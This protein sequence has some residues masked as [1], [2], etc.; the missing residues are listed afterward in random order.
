MTGRDALVAAASALA[1]LLVESLL[2]LA[3]P[4]PVDGVALAQSVGAHLVLFGAVFA[5]LAAVRAT[6][7]LT[8]NP[9]RSESVGA[10]VLLCGMV[11]AAATLVICTTLSIAGGRAA[12]VF[13]FGAVIAARFAARGL[14]HRAGP[15]TR[16]RGAGGQRT[17][18]RWAQSRRLWPRVAW[19]ALIVVVVLL[20]RSVSGAM[21]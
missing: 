2:G 12:A 18:A 7:D 21:D 5:A 14:R 10:V 4:R 6:A 3:G 20:A 19:A 8:A 1:V 11:G 9:G 17:A 15:R 16:R 13:T